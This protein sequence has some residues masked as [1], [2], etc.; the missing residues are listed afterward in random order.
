MAGH[1]LYWP[2]SFVGDDE[3]VLS[4]SSRR[5]MTREKQGNT[6]LMASPKRR[7][8]LDR[9]KGDA[10]IDGGAK[11]RIVNALGMLDETKTLVDARY[12]RNASNAPDY[13][14]A[15]LL[16]L[17]REPG[18]ISDAMTTL[19]VFA[20]GVIGDAKVNKGLIDF[21]SSLGNTRRDTGSTS[22]VGDA[23]LG[24]GLRD[25]SL[26]DVDGCMNLTT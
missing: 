21:I 16:A 24:I 15:P 20:M 18:V 22:K 9:R 7:G 12:L 23:C 5:S 26:G 2:S 8:N 13:V 3:E 14:A 25:T 11:R 19:G 6:L 10:L 1:P 4:F 17:Q